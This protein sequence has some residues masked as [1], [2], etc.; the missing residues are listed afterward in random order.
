MAFATQTFQDAIMIT[1]CFRIPYLW[2][3]ALCITQDSLDDW[4]A[5][6][7]K[8][9]QIYE[10]ADLVI[11]AGLA[12]N[13]TVGFLGRRRRGLPHIIE[14]PIFSKVKSTATR[15]CC[16]LSENPID[17]QHAYFIGSG[18]GNGLTI[19]SN[20]YDPVFDRAWCLQERFLTTRLF[21]FTSTEMIWECKAKIRCE[22]EYFELVE[23]LVEAFNTALA[24]PGFHQCLLQSSA[25]TKLSRWWRM[26]EEYSL[27]GLTK[28]TDRLPA[29]S[30][31][32]RRMEDPGLGEYLSGIWQE[33]LL[34]G[35][36]WQCD[37]I[38][39]NS[40][41][42]SSPGATKKRGSRSKI[43][44][45]PTWSWASITGP[46]RRPSRLLE[47][48]ILAAYILDI[49]C[50]PAGLDP[51]G[52][53]TGGFLQIKA[54]SMTARISSSWRLVRDFRQ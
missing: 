41:M 23:G 30:G 36:L 35:L 31:L 2:I 43:S 10:I 3:D 48:H 51:Y 37:G 32:A 11:S 46:I 49:S 12:P 24:K 28:E 22:C 19:P 50:Q 33:N 6:S 39:I 54:P 52:Q 13:N 1:R 53:V 8:M 5:E 4:Q 40:G 38:G 27:R 26:V 9:G 17:E 44:V 18:Q 42:S 14:L 16:T 45:A 20:G 21:H 34:W 7:R 47:K 15:F 25:K 29:I